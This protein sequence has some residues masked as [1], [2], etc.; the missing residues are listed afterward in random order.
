MTYNSELFSQASTQV[1]MLL[2]SQRNMVL[3]SAFAI[4]LQT[5]SA[6][7]KY[8]YIKYLAILLFL[9]AIASGS[10][11][12]QDFNKY[13]E[14]TKNGTDIADPSERELLDSWSSW[15]NY[16]YFLLAIVSFIFLNVLI[17]EFYEFK[18][19]G[20]FWKKSKKVKK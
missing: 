18:N 8:N 16:S 3:V 17:I 14:D 20:W 12:V 4:T 9:F 1:N 5:F 15:S 6:N 10:K 7:F 13:I 19:Y 11:S 2:L